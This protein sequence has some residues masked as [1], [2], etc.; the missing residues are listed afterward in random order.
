MSSAAEYKDLDRMR[1]EWLLRET[2]MQVADI[3]RKLGRTRGS[4]YQK[5][6]NLGLS[7]A[8]DRRGQETPWCGK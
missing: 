6:Y 3:A 5:M 8:G 7:I 1:L 4:V 2:D